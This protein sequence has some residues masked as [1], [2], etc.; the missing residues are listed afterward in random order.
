MATITGAST[1]SGSTEFDAKSDLRLTPETYTTLD[2]LVKTTKDFVMP[3]LVETYGDQGITGFLDMTGAVKSGGT[4]DQVD[5]WEAGR[6][7][8]TLTASTDDAAT[9]SPDAQQLHFAT[10]TNGI[11]I[12]AKLTSRTLMPFG[13]RTHS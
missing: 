7:H 11:P 3:D 12:G 5:W 1:S 9:T 13:V 10:D 8:R 6:R 4:S 2:T